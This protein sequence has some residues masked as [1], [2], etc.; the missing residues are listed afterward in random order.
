MRAF[1]SSGMWLEAQSRQDE[2]FRHSPLMGALVRG[3]KPRRILELGSCDAHL[4]YS[5]CHAVSE[6]DLPT[7]CYSISQ[8]LSD[9]S[10]AALKDRTYYEAQARNLS[11]SAFSALMRKS[12][13]DAL[14][15]FDDKAIDLLLIDARH[16]RDH[17]ENI[18]ENW[19]PKLSD[20]AIVVV[21]GADLSNRRFAD[22]RFWWSLATQ[23][24]S[25]TFPNPHQLGVL[26][27]GPK[28]PEE[29]RPLVSVLTLAHGHDLIVDH[30]QKL[31][32]AYFQSALMAVRKSRLQR[33]NQK[34]RQ[35]SQ[36]PPQQRLSPLRPANK[37]KLSF[38]RQ[39]L[40]ALARSSGVVSKRSARRFRSSAEKRD[41]RRDVLAPDQSRY[42]WSYETIRA[43]WEK[44]RRSSKKA[45]THL[46]ETLKDGP[47]ISIIATGSNPCV[48]HF[49]EFIKSVK[50]QSY[51]NWELCLTGVETFDPEVR[52][53]SRDHALRDRRVRFVSDDCDGPIVSRTNRAIAGAKGR[54]IAFAEHY[55]VLDPDALLLVARCLS[56]HPE[57]KIIYS[58]EDRINQ[59]GVFLEPH[60]KPDWNREL[61]YATNY[62][63]RLCT[64]EASLLRA[65]HGYRSGYDGSEDYELL[66]R[67]VE[68]I[69][70]RQIHHVPRV[71]Y[72]S[73]VLPV[74]VTKSS[75]AD[76]QANE[77]GRRALGEHLER[78]QKK[79]IAIVPG[80]LPGTFRPLWPITGRPLVSIIVPTR[81]HVEVLRLA[82]ESILEKTQYTN[83]ELLIVD[84][85]SVECG[86]LSWLVEIQRLDDRVR[87]LRDNRPFNYSALNN[88]AVLQ[89]HGDILA[90]VNNDV[91]V[92]SPD[93]LS[94]MVALAQRADVGC[95]GAKLY[96]SNDTIQ[97]AGVVVGLG[98]CAGHGHKLAPKESP[99]YLGRLM[100]RQEYSAV[101]GACLVVRRAIFDEVG[102]FN[103]VDLP[104]AFNDV[105][106][107]LKVQ[108]AG[109][110]NLWTPWAQLYHYESLSRGL[111]DTP[112]SKARAQK[113]I[114]YIQ[115]VWETD[116]YRDP[117][118]NPNLTL[119][120]ED[121]SLAEPVWDR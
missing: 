83:F 49:T 3:L 29:L 116:S 15:A 30:Y 91:A 35:I 90:L 75:S 31:G 95:V 87:V 62:V 115:R 57:A 107:C 110:R 74:N 92:I 112:Q 117:A 121:F 48:S 61:L 1:N 23:L 55:D 9:T 27:W 44:Q 33:E 88:D 22:A 69:E 39:F 68:Q 26:F 25:L 109:Y 86:T 111:D 104:V 118:Y 60:F 38:E 20:C 78:T 47:L 98:G 70:D 58:D 99:G 66:L 94:E 40:N 16:C 6:A 89:S 106:F 7:R 65:V 21:H 93:W 37:I 114:A 45:V 17:V 18:F 82:V 5:L 85:G 80:L 84:N 41:P 96:Y 76:I 12:P 52:R 13:H 102:G 100:V 120:S 14:D 59:E 63:S 28:T 103:Q 108:K 72:H 50:E 56:D 64:Y 101:T 67:C 4:Y 97:H 77:S 51:A 34:L 53:I 105:D 113:E 46:A 43:E 73:R 2:W 8:W 36:L 119:N 24:P 42:H 10:E 71:L 81:D 79:R 11:Y 32:E 19:T 54:Y